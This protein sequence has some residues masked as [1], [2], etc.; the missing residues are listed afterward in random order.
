MSIH[1]KQ[2][3]SLTSKVASRKG[4]VGSC[5]RRACVIRAQA[6]DIDMS[7]RVT[8]GTIAGAAAVFSGVSPSTAAYGDS[9]NVFGKVTNK[10]GFIPYAGEGFAVLLPSKWN[11][12]ALGL[13]EFPGTLLRYEDNFD[14]I[15]CF[16]ILA[17][18]TD[19]GKITDFG[20][21]EKF[22]ENIGFLFGRQSFEGE[23]QSEGGFAPNRVSAASILNVGTA[24][25]KKGKEYYTYDILTRTA[26][27]DEGGKH[28][29]IKATVADGKLWI[30]KVQVGDK[31]WIRGVDKEA[32]GVFDSFIVA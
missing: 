30:L 13:Q 12:S 22:L 28:N 9:A 5:A 20:A 2:Q 3:S 14:A 29:L 17:N 23:T 6:N 7:R 21:P 32:L 24:T 10:S 27:G 8:L 26:D 15:N 11:P 1:C 19:K 4:F 16:S 31:R 25:D 18:A